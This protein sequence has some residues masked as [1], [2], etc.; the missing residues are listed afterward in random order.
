MWTVGLGA[1]TFTFGIIQVVRSES[2]TEYLRSADEQ[3]RR[4]TQELH[5][6][7]LEHLESTVQRVV[8]LALAKEALLRKAKEEEEE[9]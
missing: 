9:E 2:K 5:K 4:H 7:F 6:M 1:M 3:M 8:E